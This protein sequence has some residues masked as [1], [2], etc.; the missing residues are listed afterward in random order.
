MYNY[1]NVYSSKKALKKYNENPV[2]VHLNYFVSDLK[3]FLLVPKC[4]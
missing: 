4:R 3:L 1:Q 2:R